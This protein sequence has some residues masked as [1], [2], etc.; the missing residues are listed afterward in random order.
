MKPGKT[1]KWALAGEPRLQYGALPWRVEDRPEI[2]LVS[3]RGAHRWI[4]PKGWPIKGYAPHDAAAQEALEEAGVV[5]KI[6]KRTVGAFHYV[7]H[8]PEGHVACRVL[9]FPLGVIRQRKT[10]QESKERVTRWFSFEEAA[11]LVREPELSQLI[12][13]FAQTLEA[14]ASSLGQGG[15]SYED[16]G[17]GPRL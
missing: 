11:T 12:A 2:L 15:K 6:G 7:K 1:S 4:I 16:S 5:G 17:I 14:K 10:W 13:E 3:T 9:V 8:C